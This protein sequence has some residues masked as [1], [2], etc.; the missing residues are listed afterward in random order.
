VRQPRPKS[1]KRR[2]PAEPAVRHD[3][4]ES[5]SVRLRPLGREEI[6][7][8][9]V[10]QLERISLQA[11]PQVEKDCKVVLERLPA[12]KMEAEK[13]ASE[14]HSDDEDALRGLK[15][16]NEG[17]AENTMMM[18][19]YEYPTF[20][21][22]SPGCHTSD[23]DDLPRAELPVTP[24][25]GKTLEPKRRAPTRREVLASSG[26]YG[27]PSQRN[28]GAFCSRSKDVPAK[29]TSIRERQI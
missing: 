21:G 9:C 16:A 4:D 17:Q 6:I 28:D 29:G 19:F 13:S 1:A 27:I 14:G 2:T 12:A 5:C 7:K 15:E 8:E 25:T 24:A 11:P 26:D 10:V 22:A 23:E 18:S 20:V 3:V